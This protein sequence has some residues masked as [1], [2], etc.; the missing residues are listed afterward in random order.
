MIKVPD[1]L[2]P[3][4][5]ILCLLTCSGL[6]AQEWKR[7]MKAV[8]GDAEQFEWLSQALKKTNP[9]DE[10][11]V[12]MLEVFEQLAGRL[13]RDSTYARL[14][15]AVGRYYQRMG[16]VKLAWGEYQKAKYLFM[17]TR[18]IDH[19]AAAVYNQ[20]I[21]L[22]SQ[23]LNDSLLNF[24]ERNKFFQ[25]QPSDRTIKLYLKNVYPMVL[26]MKGKEQEA[27]K[28]FE[29]LV[30]AALETKDTA[31]IVSL[32]IN[33]GMLQHS[34]DSAMMWYRKG[35]EA[36][37][38]EPD[39]HTE[40]LLK[41]GARYT[42]RDDALKD[43]ALYYFLEAEKNIDKLFSP[44]LR[45]QT[46][47][48]ICDFL[49]SKGEYNLALPYLRKANAIGQHMP[50]KSSN[51]ILHNL[52]VCFMRLNQPDSAKVYLEQYKQRIDQGADA[53][54]FMLYHHAM[55][56]FIGLKG[57]SCSYEVQRQRN[58]ALSYAKEIDETHIT[59]SLIVDA[60][61]CAATVKYDERMIP[62][63]KELLG[64]CGYF[65]ELLKRENKLYIYSG[66]LTGYA[67][68]EATY[69][70]KDKALSLYREL[71]EVISRIESDKYLLGHN[72]AL[73]K[74]KSELKDAELVYN[75]RKNTVLSA[76]AVLLVIVMLGIAFF[77]YRAK[78][79]NKKIRSQ[80]EQLEQINHVKDR[81]FSVIGHD[82]RAPVSSLMSLAQ[83]LEKGNITPERMEAMSVELKNKLG[84]TAGLMDNLLNWAHTQMNGYKPV[85]TRF[86][87]GETI[88]DVIILLRSEADRKHIDIENNIPENSEIYADVNMTS[89]LVRNLLS[90]AIKFTGTGGR[91][92]I[93]YMKSG[94]ARGFRIL[95]F[96]VGLGSDVVSELNDATSIR[97]LKS[98]WGTQNEKGTGIGLMLCKTFITLMGGTFNVISEQ[99]KGTRFTV[100][101]N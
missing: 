36:S 34:F 11:Y 87:L 33:L 17:K 15:M 80:K 65:R 70:S 95:D 27:L 37:K 72:E 59:T 82:L 50:G 90:N 48:F 51:L 97:P 20:C 91:I 73:V 46:E 54:Q 98:T 81:L 53:Y 101:F 45:M 2:K 71:T 86:D 4:L 76:G 47:N 88:Q 7:E 31:F 42:F 12:E 78:Q 74:Y 94:E 40:L 55:A 62:L 69:G 57:D 23:G 26:Q 10:S 25:Q 32:Y 6:S 66:F 30:P 22:L 35:L 43:S 68:L 61:E 100:M 56:K 8:K 99:G 52:A 85:M 67:H 49:M 58:L 92:V 44:V 5:V 64:Y 39:K 24:L 63:M 77:L 96:G 1:L 14:H 84:Y 9:A 18:L 16:E 21:I 3:V 29:E 83:V 38:N 79:L 75:K 13:N 93:D 41:I 19:A 89:L 28:A 60:V